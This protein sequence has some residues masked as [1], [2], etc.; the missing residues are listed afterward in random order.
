MS[1]F[2]GVPSASVT[3][4][5]RDLT[6]SIEFN[7]V[8]VK[9]GVDYDSSLSKVTVYPKRS[10]KYIVS[11]SLYTSALPV[12]LYRVLIYVN[13]AEARRAQFNFPTATTQPQT[14]DVTRLLD[15]NYGDEVEIKLWNDSSSPETIDISA[16]QNTTTLDIARLG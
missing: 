12:G 3:I 8:K 13:G 16:A 14:L 10:S 2:R 9:R 15:L 11:V 7:S 4:P 5:H 6:T 1:S